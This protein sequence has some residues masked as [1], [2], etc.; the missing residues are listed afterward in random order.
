METVSRT[1]GLRAAIRK[2]RARDCRIAF[3]P[4]MGNLHAGHLRLVAHARS[5]A[6]CVVISIFVNPLQFGAG[7]DLAGYPRTLAADQAALMEADADLLFVPAEDDIYPG[8]IAATTTVVVPGLNAILEGAH[9]PTHFD[10]VTTVVARL[11]NM[12]QPDVAVF[13][14]KDY[15]Q[16]LIIR[17]MV[18]ELCMPVAIEAVATV[19]EADG[20]AMSSRN[21][22]LRARERGR[23]PQIY[24]TLLDVKARVENGGKDYPAMEAAACRQLAAAG[25]DPDYV[26]IRRQS[27]LASPAAGDRALIVLAAARLGTTRLIDN[28]KISI[29]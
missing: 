23:A 26:S 13:G 4:T 8:G 27:D 20:L 6:D 21:G 12:V 29:S 9:R 19:R 3:V 5:I 18:T 15:Q 28:V 17:R 22:Y 16:L 1:A 7:E 25:L 11:F 24:R 14:E 2:R 10:G